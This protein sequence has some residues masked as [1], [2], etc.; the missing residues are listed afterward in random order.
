MRE[1]SFFPTATGEPGGK[2]TGQ[3]MTHL[4]NENGRFVNVA[5][6]LLR[7]HPAILYHD[8]RSENDATRKKK[9]ASKIKYTCPVCGL[10]AWAKP[11]AALVCGDCKMVMEAEIPK[12]L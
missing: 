2:E 10:N 3:K 5:T 6:I 12:E 11:E 9:A 7:D 8:L 4:I 1:I